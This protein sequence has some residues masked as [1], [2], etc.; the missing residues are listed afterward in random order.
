[1]QGVEFRGWDS[2]CRVRGVGCRVQGVGCRVVLALGVEDASHGF[3][4]QRCIHGNAV[5]EVDSFCGGLAL[6]QILAGRVLALGV[7]DR[8]GAN[9]GRRAPPRRVES[10]ISH[11]LIVST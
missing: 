7:D 11:A 3:R 1:M 8:A 5:S 10:S 2:G 6:A 9:H 4:I